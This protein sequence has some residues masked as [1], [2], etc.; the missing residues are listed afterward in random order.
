M[1]SCDTGAVSAFD[2]VMHIFLFFE[3]KILVIVGKLKNW[4]DGVVV[5]ASASRSVDLGFIS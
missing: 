4:C 2:T 5:R 1:V 3:T